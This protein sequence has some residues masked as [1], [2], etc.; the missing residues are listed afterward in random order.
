MRIHSSILAGKIYKY[1]ISE[2][3]G[4]VRYPA[5]NADAPYRQLLPA[6]PYTIFP[7]GILNGRIFEKRYETE[8]CFYFL[9]TI[10]V[11]PGTQLSDSLDTN[12]QGFQLLPDDALRHAPTQ[13]LHQQPHTAVLCEGEGV[14][15]HTFLPIKG[16]QCTD[17]GSES[18]GG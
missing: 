14:K 13:V 3:V 1:Y 16:P 18:V 9:Y 10:I 15:T 6:M 11:K 12:V 5:C 17:R 7:H 4:N 2:C 8:N